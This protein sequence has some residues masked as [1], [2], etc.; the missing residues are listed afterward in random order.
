MDSSHSSRV[1]YLHLGGCGLQGSLPWSLLGQ[2]TRL[3]LLT[4]SYNP[5]LTGT[6]LGEEGLA[7]LTQLRYLNLY[8]D[9]Q[10]SG[11]VPAAAL[12]G[13]AQ[14]R[15][16][17]LRSTQVDAAQ[18]ESF[19]DAHASTVSNGC[20]CPP[21]PPPPPP[22]EMEVL[23]QVKVRPGAVVGVSTGSPVAAKPPASGHPPADWV[24]FARYWKCLLNRTAAPLHPPVSCRRLWTRAA[25]VAASVAG[26]AV[27][28]RTTAPGTKDMMVA[29]SPESCAAAVR[30]R[31]SLT[32]FGITTTWAAPWTATIQPSSPTC[33]WIAVDWR[34]AYRGRYSV[35]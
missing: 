8:G 33:I 30:R 11:T 23:M 34:E 24:C 21:L 6:A 18:C 15:K 7:A 28:Q 13:L 9:E 12:G 19:C 10:L 31:S 5:D 20:Q 17:D 32:G 1:T 3:Q 22:S 27:R 2:L 4:I 29:V 16:L 26:G 35:S 14:L 25:R